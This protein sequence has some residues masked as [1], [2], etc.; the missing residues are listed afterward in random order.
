M[1]RRSRTVT[2]VLLAAVLVLA[3]CGGDDD[4]DDV[5]APASDDPGAAGEFTSCVP[6]E[7]EPVDG[8]TLVFPATSDVDTL[9]VHESASFNVHNR[10][11]LVYNR[12]LAY[13]V[14]ADVASGEQRIV[15]DLAEEWEVADDGLTYTFHLRDDVQWQDVPPLDGREFVADDV[16]ATMER[17]R[18]VGHQAYMLTNVEE[19]VAVDDK[20]VEFRLSEPFAPL[21]DYMA[22]PWMW[23][24][25]REAV[26]GLTDME[27]TAIG[28]GPFI[29]ERREPRVTTTYRKNPDFF[30]EGL[31]HLDRVENPV[32]SDPAAQVAAFRVGQV[33]WV[34]GLSP[35][36]L[37]AVQRSVSGS[38][39]LDYL[40]VVQP[41][42]SMNQA[43]EP[44][45]NPLVREAVSLAVDRETLID[46]I[47]GGGVPGSPVTPILG[48]WALDV[49]ERRELQPYDPD[50]AMELL[51]EAG[52]PDGFDTKLMVTTGYG[53]PTV[54]A[55]QWVAED[56]TAVGIRAEIEQ[57]EYA[58]YFGARLPN[59]E[60]EIVLG[61]QTFFAPD[62]WL[63]GVHHSESSRN[64]S[65]IDDPEMDAMLE[66]WIGL[67]DRDEA[68][69]AAKEIQRYQMRELLNP[70]YLGAYPTDQLVQPR[71]KNLCQIPYYGY[72]GMK[73]VWLEE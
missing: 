20:T 40:G 15:G 30:R 16:V 51:A 70:V 55:G 36:E 43:V 48:D 67:T 45:S 28:T 50:R 61:L 35:E 64:W 4:G 57:V 73:D 27:T 63:R 46:S 68:I 7:G 18:E 56:L 3:A 65:N 66:E 59:V 47:W 69:A 52:Y 39:P 34:A 22:S 1:A 26:E 13:E 24:V 53:S 17:V 49:E 38:V 10:V 62:E 37:P 31:P 8:G 19:V 44:W 21:L 5:T 41:F 33:D 60:Y 6:T 9:D 25:S 23:I 29:M 11:G 12:L 54:R 58:T 72:Y 2:A 32:I 14:G 71:V 42:L